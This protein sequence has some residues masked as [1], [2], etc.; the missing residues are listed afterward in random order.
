LA[1]NATYFV[2]ETLEADQN[3]AVEMRRALAAMR[4]ALRAVA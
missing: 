2:T 4:L 1:P 3:N